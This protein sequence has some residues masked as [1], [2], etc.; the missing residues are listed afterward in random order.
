MKREKSAPKKKT[1]R[2]KASAL[3]GPSEL[4]PTPPPAEE[5]VQLA[6]E[7]P[8]KTSFR[9]KLCLLHMEAKGMKATKRQFVEQAIVAALDKFDCEWGV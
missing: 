3:P 8:T 5:R 2:T 4:L 1:S 7:I 6:V 9:I